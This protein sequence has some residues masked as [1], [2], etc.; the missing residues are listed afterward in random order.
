MWLV[1]QQGSA[2]GDP[3]GLG[4]VRVC[5][6]ASAWCAER[7]HPSKGLEGD[8]EAPLPIKSQ[9]IGQVVRRVCEP[10]REEKPPRGSGWLLISTMKGLSV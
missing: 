6:E 3:R 1:R 4:G 5:P 8:R 9:R 7:P 2:V 10:A